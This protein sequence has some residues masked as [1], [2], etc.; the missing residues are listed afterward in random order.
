MGYRR[1]LFIGLGGSGGKTIRYLKRDFNEWLIQAGWFEQRT[2]G[3][4]KTALPAGVQFLNID[5]PSQQ[6]GLTARGAKLSDS[7]Y[8]GLV[9][10]GMSMEGIINALDAG[11]SEGLSLTGWRVSKYEAVDPTIA[12]GQMR[13]VG[14]SIARAYASSVRDALSRSMSAIDSDAAMSDMR[15][16]FRDVHGAASTG[17]SNHGSTDPSTERPIT[18]FISSLAGGTGAGLLFDV[19]DI[20]RSLEPDWATLSVGIW[21]TPDAFP[22]S[23]GTGLRPNA[24][25]AISE[26]LNGAWWQP[27]PSTTKNVA[28]RERDT[29]ALQAVARLPRTVERSGVQFNYLVGQK[30]ISG[31]KMDSDARLFEKVGGALLSWV[32][33]PELQDSLVYHVWGNASQRRDM[34]RIELPW[35]Y[36]KPGDAESAGGV[37]IFDSLGFSRV[38]LGTKYLR[39]YAVQRMGRRVVEHLSRAHVESSWADA[40][41]QSSGFTTPQQIT[42]YIVEQQFAAYRDM[43]DVGATLSDEARQD[44]RRS[45]GDNSDSA[46]ELAR[47]LAGLVEAALEPPVLHE[48]TDGQIE[49]LRRIAAGSGPQ[50]I[51]DW[52]AQL[53]PTIHEDV[54]GELLRAVQRDLPGKVAQWA[55]SASSHVPARVEDAI[56]RF[57]LEIATGFVDT[58]SDEIRDLVLPELDQLHIDYV[59]WSNRRAV[60]DAFLEALDANI[61]DD[62][63]VAPEDLDAAIRA[64]VRALSY[65]ASDEIVRAGQEL[66]RRFRDGFLRPLSTELKRASGA[67]QM[68]MHETEE[69]PSWSDDSMPPAHLEPPRSESTVIE[70]QEFGGIFS[71]LLSQT[72]RDLSLAEAAEAAT[73]DVA[74][75]AFARN[76]A[77]RRD[78]NDP[79]RVD[80]EQAQVIDIRRRWVV[81]F[82]LDGGDGATAPLD[83]AVRCELDHVRARTELWLNQPDLPFG[84]FL[85]LNLRTY[86]DGDKAQQDR[87]LSKLQAA[88]STALPLVELY[89]DTVGNLHRKMMDESNRVQYRIT[90]VPFSN[91]SIATEV[92]QLLRDRVFRDLNND[93]ANDAIKSIMAERSELPY[94]DIVSWLS[95]PVSPLAVKTLLDPLIESWTAAKSE[96][97][98]KARYWKNR[99][100]RPLGEFIPLPQEQLI[101]ALR[102]WFTGRAIGL[103]DVG[104]TQR[105]PFRILGGSQTTDPQ[106]MKFPDAFLSDITD[107]SDFGAL[108]LESLSLAIALAPQTR[109]AS[110]APFVELVKLGMS[111]P[112]D[113]ANEVL[114]YGSPHPAV[115]DWIDN[116]SITLRSTSEHV[117]DSL[118]EAS[119][120][121]EERRARLQGFFTQNREVF[122]SSMDL[123][124]EESIQRNRD[125]LNGP[126][127]WPGLWKQI[128]AAHHMLAEAVGAYEIGSSS[129]NSSTTSGPVG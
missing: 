78:T 16:L 43:I 70:N 47:T 128:D 87:V 52:V 4:R 120:G 119:G 121:A 111:D 57:G 26:M 93:D 37:P 125:A 77:S 20:F 97:R 114:N 71:R 85:A 24:L 89:D 49:E 67:L 116:G 51:S 61:D 127:L 48:E 44:L 56:G 19:A 102:G 18:V 21:F 42:Q 55:K 11:D 117:M 3:E 113:P 38:S 69:W 110:L 36:G 65:S 68:Q 41:R 50:K 86:T 54:R 73:T 103:I 7:E 27:R 60:E 46:A 10:P 15:Q 98:Q 80:F 30:N 83:I 17:E 91:S 90:K 62:R 100:A 129:R 72:Y 14:R 13:A 76:E 31:Q 9:A 22:D 82:D 12:A 104:S 96:P 108:V 95:T 32:V 23:Y 45:H 118:I 64:A 126:P 34:E 53:M 115:K 29:R 25:A 94:I 106:W 112:T 59:D 88:L 105:P 99:K 40:A 8:R 66:L 81:G 28:I 33:D 35:N 1:M 84:T 63:K 109:N 75:G 123:Y 107:P 74:S 124:L 5:T 58:F 122:K 79:F 92:R 101:A 6:D 39:G 2:T